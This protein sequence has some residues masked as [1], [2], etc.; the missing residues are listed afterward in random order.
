LIPQ[1]R[2]PIEKMDM[3]ASVTP[4]KLAEVPRMFSTIRYIS[5]SGY[6]NTAIRDF[7]HPIS[8]CDV[9]KKLMAHLTVAAEML[10]L[11]SQWRGQSGGALRYSWRSKIYFDAQTRK[12][13]LRKSMAYGVRA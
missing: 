5:M 8:T 11:S 13:W 9:L 3:S 1:I 6:I 2:K 7:K 10:A 12:P 4:R